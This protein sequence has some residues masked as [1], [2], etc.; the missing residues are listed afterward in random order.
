M[1]NHIKS[2]F[3][4]FLFII[5]VIGILGIYFFLYL[6]SYNMKKRKLKAIEKI[7]YNHNNL[8]ITNEIFIN[9]EK[10]DNLEKLYNNT[11]SYSYSNK[12]K[13]STNFKGKLKQ[14]K[15]FSRNLFDYYSVILLLN[16]LSAYF[17]FILLFSFFVRND[18]RINFCVRSTSGFH[19]L[20]FGY[21]R[22]D[23][24]LICFDNTKGQGFFLLMIFL[25][26]IFFFFVI[27]FFI[28]KFLGK[29]LSRYI[30]LISFIIFNIINIL[31]CV[32]YINNNGSDDNYSKYI[33]IISAILLIIN[34]L[35]VL[36]PNLKCFKIL[37]KEPSKK[38]HISH[39]SRS[40][41]SK[42]IK[43]LVKRNNNIT[44]IE[45]NDNY[46]N[47]NAFPMTPEQN[48]EKNG[49]IINSFLANNKS[50][51]NEKST[52]IEDISLSVTRRDFTS[53]R[54]SISNIEPKNF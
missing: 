25:M 2:S 37:T 15:L 5:N 8:K 14:R 12:D 52:N 36:L 29:N 4:F 18:E 27:I 39:K 46:N 53:D 1:A 24:D 6:Y 41:R 26:I 7:K 3:V 23:H 43:S 31:N 19:C 50:P 11:Y 30:S 33:L 48:S 16:S 45:N 9:N 22:C 54:K 28:A 34:I 10:I 44:N 38:V 49:N 40:D 21:Y 13:F 17:C 35:G 51:E 47:N 32:S 20:C 42:S